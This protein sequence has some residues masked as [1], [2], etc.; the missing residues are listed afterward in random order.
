MPLLPLL[1]LLQERGVAFAFSQVFDQFMGEV[2]DE[3]VLGERTLSHQVATIG[4]A[5]Q[6]DEILVKTHLAEPVLAERRKTMDD[7][8]VAESAHQVLRDHSGKSQ[9]C[10]VCLLLQ[11]GVGEEEL[12]IGPGH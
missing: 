11:G 1:V 9:L 7:D 2:V 10:P 8:F 4:A 6:V 5:G 12:V 3:D